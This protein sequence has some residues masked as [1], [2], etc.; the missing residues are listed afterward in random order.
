MGLLLGSIVASVVGQFLL[1]A[2]ALRLGKVTGDNWLSHLLS[3]VT[4]WEL[5][6]GLTAYG[7]GA[8]TYILLLTRVKLSIAAPSVSLIYV[9]TV[10]IGVVAFGESLPIARLVGVGLI[11]TGVVLVASQS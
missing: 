9:F 8:I 4:T 11:M 2:G 7:L 3:M 1:K 10:L 6:A 5:V